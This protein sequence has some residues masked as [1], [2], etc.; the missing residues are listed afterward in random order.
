M[1]FPKKGPGP[2]PPLL[3]ISDGYVVEEGIREVSPIRDGQIKWATVARFATPSK[4][5]G[6]GG[7]GGGGGAEKWG[8]TTPDRRGCAAGEY[9]PVK[10]LDIVRRYRVRP[11]AVRRQGGELVFRFS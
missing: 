2:P 8:T 11:R 4:C 10:R 7:G 5:D 9:G 6:G 3:S 1:F